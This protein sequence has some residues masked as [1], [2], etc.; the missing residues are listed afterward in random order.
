MIF[1]TKN[2]ISFLLLPILFVSLAGS[3]LPRYIAPI[4]DH[5]QSYILVTLYQ[6]LSIP[7]KL[8]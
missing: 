2:M 1:A 7:C 4:Q 3:V 5:R 6:S 8:C